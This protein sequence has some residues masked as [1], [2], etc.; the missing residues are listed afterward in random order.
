MRIGSI[1]EC[2]KTPKEP[3]DLVIYPVKGNLYTIRGIHQS[4][5]SVYLEEICN[6]KISHLTPSKREPGFVFGYFRELLPPMEINIEAI[7][8]CESLI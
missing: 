1:V 7:I 3:F 6:K 5:G 2:I 8:E 4:G